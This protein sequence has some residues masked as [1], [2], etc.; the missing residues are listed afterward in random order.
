MMGRAVK[1]KLDSGGQNNKRIISILSF[2]DAVIRSD[3][4]PLA[5]DVL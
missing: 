5:D 1:R 3:H 2:N 4:T